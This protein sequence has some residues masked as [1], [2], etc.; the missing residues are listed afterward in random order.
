ML[1]TLLWWLVGRRCRTAE[2]ARC[3]LMQRCPGE[4]SCCCCCC[5][6][7]LSLNTWQRQGFL[8]TPDLCIGGCYI[9]MT[10]W[11]YLTKI[12]TNHTL[13][14]HKASKSPSI[15]ASPDYA[16][17]PTPHM[18]HTAAQLSPETCAPAPYCCCCCRLEAHPLVATLQCNLGGALLALHR[19][20][21]VGL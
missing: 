4:L 12:K 13:H 1:R 17:H 3:L 7:A 9:L 10:L 6:R 15:M 11:L 5:H 16:P 18:Q 14:L 8:F 2:A 19:T 20:A 21:L